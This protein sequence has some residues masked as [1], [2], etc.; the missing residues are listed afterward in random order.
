MKNLHVFWAVLVALQL[1]LVST[2]SAQTPAPSYQWV[3]VMQ[4]SRDTTYDSNTAVATTIDRAG[5]VYTTI[6]FTSDTIL[7]GGNPYTFPHNTAQLGLSRWALVKYNS[8]G[9]VVWL[10]PD[11]CTQESNCL[12][13]DSAGNLFCWGRITSDDVIIDN[14]PV[15]LAD[16]DTYVAKWAPNGTLLWLHQFPANGWQI[17][18]CMTLDPAGNPIVGVFYQNTASF[19]PFPVTQNNYNI[20][21]TT[22]CAAIAKLSG[23]TGVVQW[24]TTATALTLGTSGSC[25]SLATDAAGNVY[26]QGGYSGGAFAVQGFNG[27]MTPRGRFRSFV[28][29]LTP[30]GQCVQFHTFDWGKFRSNYPDM[31]VAPDGTTFI[32]QSLIEPI[33]FGGAPIAP[34]VQRDAL[35][36]RLDPNGNVQQVITL[37]ASLGADT[38]RVTRMEFDNHGNLLLAGGIQENGDPRMQ[39]FVLCLEPAG[40]AT[41]WQTRITGATSAS[42]FSIAAADGQL[43]IGGSWGGPSVQIGPFTRTHTSTHHLGHGFL[44]KLLQ[45]YNVL[46]GY[47]FNDANRNGLRDL[48]EGGVPGGAIVELQPGSRYMSTGPDGQYSAF[49]QLGTFSTSLPNPPRYY[50]AVPVG[51]PV[52]TAFT[53]FG[54]VATGQSFA[55][56]PIA[57]QQDLS[58]NVT[59]ITRA[60]PGFGVRYRVTFRNAGTVA[61]AAGTVKLTFDPL[62]QYLAST[63]P[64][65]AQLNNTLTWP[66][67]NLLPGQERSFDVTFQLLTTA[68]IGN[69]LQTTAALTPLTGDLTPADND[70]T[71]RLTVTGSYDPNDIEVN[72]T[73]LTLTQVTGGEWLEYTIRFRNIGTDTAFSVMLRDTLPATL[74]NLGSLTLLSVSHNCRWTLSQEGIFTVSFTGTSF[75]PYS[76]NT[77]ASDGFVRFRVRPLATLVTGDQIPNRAAILFDFNAPMATNTALTSIGQ[78]SSLVASLESGTPVVIWPNPTTDQLYLEI[79]SPEAGSLKLA[80]IDALG[81]TVLARTVAKPIGRLHTSLDLS[82][83]CSGIYQ[84]RGTGGSTSFTRRV[85]IP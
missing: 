3:D 56:Q 36:A 64:G 71:S 66:Y 83:L 54:N 52:N 6:N 77:I 58:V 60:R 62:L 38:V 65:G 2:G 30:A 24:A 74:L 42:L 67:A 32:K 8:A 69:V 37:A 31:S 47:A 17:P 1:A 12:R 55:L 75:P 80:L 51:G 73:H 4:S 10:K 59:A 53:T 72:Y 50:Q 57:G 63:L 15:P 68:P 79:D 41:Q 11:V 34:G 35:L 46:N 9:Q 20:D 76:I 22:F 19:D 23:A 43:V 81:R 26:W 61:I 13:V 7:L 48:G 40:F 28:A 5:N 49:L 85:V 14:Q 84:A 39:A 44:T 78:L 29:K 33:V 82:N 16:G 45:N 70:E 21:S 18:A 27:A 25:Y